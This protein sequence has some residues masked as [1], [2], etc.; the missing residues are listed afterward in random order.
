MEVETLT[1]LDES[2]TVFALLRQINELRQE[3]RAEKAVTL[4]MGRAV[5]QAE[6]RCIEA[7]DRIAE[8]ERLAQPHTPNWKRGELL[9]FVLDEEA[10]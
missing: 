7:E 8:Y 10:L 5:I 9:A 2:L 1:A 6:A 3:L 4:M